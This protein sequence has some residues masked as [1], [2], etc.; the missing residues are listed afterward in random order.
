M[1]KD[2]LGRKMS[3]DD[4]C[5]SLAAMLG[6]GNTPPWHVL[7]RDLAAKLS[8]LRE[9]STPGKDSYKSLDEFC[10]EWKLPLSGEDI[11]PDNRGQVCLEQ[12]HAPF[13]FW[14]DGSIR[15]TPDPD[16]NKQSWINSL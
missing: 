2:H 5:R 7:E 1:S 13:Y 11:F 14:M 16:F 4:I 12:M 15:S 8:R 10:R 3:A 9:L 6:W